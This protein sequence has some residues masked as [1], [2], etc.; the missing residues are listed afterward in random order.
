[1]D[2]ETAQR[3]LNILGN[4]ML[5]LESVEQNLNRMHHDYFDVSEI[6]DQKEKLYAMDNLLQN[7]LKEI[8][9]TSRKIRYKALDVLA[10]ENEIKSIKIELEE[11]S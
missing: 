2:S 5:S 3:F 6:S 11:K 4:I 9:H 8:A 7:Y 10:L 1:M